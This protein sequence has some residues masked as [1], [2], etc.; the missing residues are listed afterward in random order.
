MV[1]AVHLQPLVET[2]QNIVFSTRSLKTVKIAMFLDDFRPCKNVVKTNAFS[3]KGTKKH[4]AKYSVFGCFWPKILDL[5]QQQQQQQQQQRQQQ[6][7][8]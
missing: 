6:H 8:E 1:F 2:P 5:D 3:S 4:G 7:K